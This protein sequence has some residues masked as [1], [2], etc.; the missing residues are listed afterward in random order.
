[1]PMVIQYNWA[2]AERKPLCVSVLSVSLWNEKYMFYVGD[3]SFQGPRNEEYMWFKDLAT[4]AKVSTS[5]NYTFAG[6]RHWELGVGF[7]SQHN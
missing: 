4:T 6:V 3:D 5:E 1:M 2:D 7:F